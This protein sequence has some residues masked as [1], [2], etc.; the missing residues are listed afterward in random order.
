MEL[1]CD[2]CGVIDH[3]IVDGYCFGDRLLEGVEFMVKDK[4]GKPNALG[5]KPECQDYFSDLNQKKWLKACEEFCE[6]LDIAQCP[7]CGDDVVVWGNPVVTGITPPAPKVIQ[8]TRGS[9]SDLINQIFQ[10]QVK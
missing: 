4:N 8:M 3:I 6:Q 2:T 10:R 9:G 5:V 7:K 1:K